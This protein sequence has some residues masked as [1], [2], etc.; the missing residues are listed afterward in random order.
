MVFKA[1]GL[2]VGTACDKTVKVCVRRQFI[3]PV[4]HKVV[5]TRKNFLAHDPDNKVL[6]GD[7][8]EITECQKISKRKYTRVTNI[9]KEVEKYRDPETGDIYTRADEYFKSGSAKASK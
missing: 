5:R 1:V 2:V 9:I 7:V 4:F 6:K 3:H 8:V